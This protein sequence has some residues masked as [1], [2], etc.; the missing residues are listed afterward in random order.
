MLKN[1]HPLLNAAL[2]GH[3]HA[4]GHGDEI[5]IVDRNFPAA[6]CAT[7]L[8]ELP[9]TTITE[10]AEAVFSVF[11]V[12]TFLTPASF[13][14]GPVGDEAAEVPAHQAFQAAM[15]AGEGRAIETEA[16]ER[17]AFYERVRGA[18]VVVSTSDD[19]PYANFVVVKGV[20]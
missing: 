8:V 19:R 2:L 14:M 20:V 16:L 10:V 11:P 17:F 1:L 13:R 15:E 3:L 7:R 6:S 9:G 4:M 18:Y 5:A 12:D